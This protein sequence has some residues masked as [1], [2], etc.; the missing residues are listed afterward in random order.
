MNP[1]KALTADFEQWPDELLTLALLTGAGLLILIALRPGHP[2][3][4]A[5]TLAYI[6]LP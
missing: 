2:W 1:W 4:K 6:V 5:F 3:Q